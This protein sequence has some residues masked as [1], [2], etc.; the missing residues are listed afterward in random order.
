MDRVNQVIMFNDG[1]VD[2]CV[3]CRPGEVFVHRNVGNLVLGN[4]LNALS[5]LEFA[6][7]NLNVTDIIVTG[8]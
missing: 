8:R 1:D 7:G 3:S 4:D 6:V 2:E 5:V